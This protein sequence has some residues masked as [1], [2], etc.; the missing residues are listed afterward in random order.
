[1]T[2]DVRPPARRGRPRKAAGASALA[3]RGGLTLPRSGLHERASERL[4]TMI[5]EGELAPGA[6]LVEVELSNAL[7]ISRTP[8]REALKLLAQDGLVE[9]RANRSPRV[10]ALDAAAIGELFEALSGVERMAA[11]LA[12]ARITADE[13]RRLA[14]LQAAIV[15]EHHAGRRAAYFAANRTI[16]RTIVE[17]ARNRTIADLHAVLLGRAEQVRFFALRLEDR[18]EQSIVEHQAILDALAARDAEAAGRLLGAHVGHTADVVAAC[19]AQG[20]VIPPA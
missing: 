5:V 14:D 13:L 19:L 11:E 2:Q 1:M 6:P 15:S 12:A 17:A 4:R 10:R 16:H 18:W 20:L 7:G 9:L 3:G 8:L